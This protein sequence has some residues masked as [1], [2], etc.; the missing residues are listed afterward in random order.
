MTLNHDVVPDQT[1][2]EFHRALVVVRGDGRMYASSTGGQRSSKVGSL[3]GA[4]AL[5]CL[6]ASGDI[7]V[8]GSLVDA[9]LIGRIVAEAE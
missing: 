3:K 8:K 6:P 1:R 4:N 7:C 2:P 9:L 5:L